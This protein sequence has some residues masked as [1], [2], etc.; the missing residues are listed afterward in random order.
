MGFD[1]FTAAALEDPYSQYA[2]FREHEPVHR[3][4]K[5]EAEQA[6]RQLTAKALD[7][8]GHEPTPWRKLHNPGVALPSFL[9]V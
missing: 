7:S 4:E 6:D 5:L 9:A 3:S 8:G 2:E 1:P